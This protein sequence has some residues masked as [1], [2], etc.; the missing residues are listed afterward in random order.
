MIGFDAAADILLQGIRDRAFPAASVEIGRGAGALWGHAFGSLTYAD[1][2]PPATADTIF[3]L[4]S[5][6]KV[7][8]TTTL[9]MRG[10]SESNVIS[11]K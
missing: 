9:T 10:D 6:T 8:A 4:A 11:P 3:D 2:A 1:D 7:I 5:L